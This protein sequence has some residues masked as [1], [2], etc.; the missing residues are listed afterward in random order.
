[1][2]VKLLKA[3]LVA[4][5]LM[6]SNTAMAGII[7]IGSYNLYDGP[8]WTTNPEVYSAIE[9]AEEIFGSPVNGNY[10]ISINGTDINN[11]SQSAWYD[12]VGNGVSDFIQSYRL[13]SNDDGYGAS[14]WRSGDDASAYVRD[15]GGS[16][17]FINYVFLQDNTQ[18]PEPSTLAIFAL[19]IIGLASRKIKK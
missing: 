7:Y 5:V 8:A 11:I 6:L 13:D 9:A 2:N 4:V 16:G 14:G 10:L 1:M 18:V 12:V 15:N 3:A 19:G 17:N